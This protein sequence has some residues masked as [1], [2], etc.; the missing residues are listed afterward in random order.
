MEA[1]SGMAGLIKAALSLK[2]RAIPPNLHFKT[3]NPNI[4]F[5]DL[6]LRVPTMLETWPDTQGRPAFAGA[7]SFGF[8]GTNAHVVLEEAAP[9]DARYGRNVNV[10]AAKSFLLPISARDP[11]ALKDLASAYV[12]FLAADAGEEQPDFADVAY[13]TALRRGHHH[14]RLAVVASTAEQAGAAFQNILDGLE[15]A[16][17]SLEGSFEDSRLAF[18]FSGMGTQW[19]AMARPTR[20]NRACILLRHRRVRQAASELCRLVLGRIANCAGSGVTD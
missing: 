12:N 1:A 8:G 3:P 6:K 18:V 7:N 15:D 4:A 17:P 10:A 19:W 20:R 9:T 11:A 14:H 16:D 13:S 2:H 5:D